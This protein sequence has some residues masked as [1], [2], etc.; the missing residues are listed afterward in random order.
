MAKYGLHKN[1]TFESLLDT[2]LEYDFTNVH[3]YNR[4]AVNF[5]NG[6][7]GG[8][9]PIEEL[10]DH[11][12]DDKHEAVLAKMMAAAADAERQHASHME[13]ARQV[14]RQNAMPRHH[15]AH[16][17]H[18]EAEPRF[19]NIL[20]EPQTFRD[21]M[22]RRQESYKA[23]PHVDYQQDMNRLREQA[24]LAAERHQVLQSKRTPKPKQF[25]LASPPP[26]PPPSP[27]GPNDNMQ[28]KYDKRLL[29]SMASRNPRVKRPQ[30]A[31]ATIGVKLQQSRERP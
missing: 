12:H 5:R 8:P 13:Q 20:E 3:I 23:N 19:G 29:A 30:T 26:S 31:R 16:E 18:T 10:V 25:N 11:E 15:A 22:E 9:A 4:A 17:I 7:F 2:G 21:K 1:S 24:R 14:Y 28:Q 27:R 6:F